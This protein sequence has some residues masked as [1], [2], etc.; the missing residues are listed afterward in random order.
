[1]SVTDEAEARLPEQHPGEPEPEAAPAPARRWRRWSTLAPSLL[2]AVLLLAS[3]LLTVLTAGL[4]DSPAAGNKALTDTAA[5]D[6]VTGEI[7]SALGRI[8]SYS[9]DSLA[10]TERDAKTLLRGQAAKEYDALLASVRQRVTDQGLT[11]TTQVVRIGVSHLSGDTA[12]LL[13]FLDQ[14]TRRDGEKAT[15]VPAQLSVTAEL[16]GGHWRITKLKAR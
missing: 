12:R 5:T 7:R 8:L 3:T 11:L 6:R 14:T 10:A 13:A 2:S 15:A 4:H 9:P 16:D 1:M